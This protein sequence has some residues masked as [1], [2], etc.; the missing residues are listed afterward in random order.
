MN[1]NDEYVTQ[2][3]LAQMREEI[4]R[5][6]ERGRIVVPT[7]SAVDPNNQAGGANHFSNS[8]FNYSDAAATVLGTLPATVGDDNQRAWRIFRQKQG[9]PVVFTDAAS[10]KAV[11]HSLYAANEGVNGYIP[12]W[13]RIRGFLIMGSAE[14]SD[15]YD[16]AMQLSG[17]I[18][19]QSEEWFFC[20]QCATLDPEPVPLAL[21]MYAGLWEK[22][23]SGEGWATGA[24]FSLSH[25][26]TGARGSTST[27]YRV[28]AKTDSG[29]SILSAVLTVPDAPDVPSPVDYVSVSVNSV[30][31]AG[32]FEFAIYKKVAG[33]FFYLFTIR[34]TI[35]FEFHDDAT[36]QSRLV[37]A[38][39]AADPAPLAYAESRSL[40]IGGYGGGWPRN[41]LGIHVPPAYNYADTNS[42]GQSLR[43]GF[44]IPTA[45]NRQIGVDYCYFSTSYG[46]WAA[47][48][49]APFSDRT[50]PV[51]SISPTSSSQGTG[52]SLGPPPE[53]GSGGGL[54]ERLSRLGEII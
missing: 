8:D 19:K 41:R 31:D 27:E 44:T 9:D 48:V 23:G 43:F 3:Q 40:L 11:D 35:D 38:W 49:M 6:L 12:I 25:R 24:N 13:D 18:V 2:A 26:I 50:Y 22:N 46:K 4:V 37:D 29:V 42:D 10:L 33:E 51:P 47:D 14:G 32:F 16:I 17:K 28:L 20:F 34:N 45:V 30:R 21:Q 52:G 54:D 1:A 15:Q 5:D 53:S 39:P 36:T 7:V